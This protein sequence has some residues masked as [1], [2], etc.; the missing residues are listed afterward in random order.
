MCQ[1]NLL[2]KE[3]KQMIEQD[4]I[5]M[6]TKLFSKLGCI[7]GITGAGVVKTHAIRIWIDKDKSDEI[8]TELRQQIPSWYGGYPV[9]IQEMGQPTFYDD[10]EV[11]G[12]IDKLKEIFP[13]IGSQYKCHL[14]ECYGDNNNIHVVAKFDDDAS[15][16]DL[17]GLQDNLNEIFYINVEVISY[18]VYKKLKKEGRIL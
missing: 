17:I 8:K 6:K 15:L 12:Q 18:Y 1:K 3:W 16:F 4:I 2:L 14:K 11:K 5:D 7:D 9:V 10:H 13:S